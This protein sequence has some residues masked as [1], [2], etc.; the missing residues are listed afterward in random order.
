M[1][2]PPPPPPNSLTHTETGKQIVF[3]TNNSTKSRADYKKKL[4]NMG[5][6]C[7][8]LTPNPPSQDEVFGSSYSAAI[9]I[10]RILALPSPKNKIFVLG[11]AGIEAELR[12]ESLAYIGGS[13]PLLRRD[14]TPADYAGIASGEML[15]PDVGVV[16]CGLDFHI[17][18]LKLSLGYHYLQRGALFLATNTD[19]TLPAAG[20]FFPGAGATTAAALSAMVEG[21]KPVALGK[22][23]QAMM[24]AIEG[25]FRFERART[26]MVGDRLDTDIK[27]GI[28]GKLGGT[29]AVLTGVARREEWEGEGRE[30]VPAA[31]VDRLGDLMG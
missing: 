27:F 29:L 26:C 22:P 28:E 10:S 12:S 8:V 20:T 7:K 11:E 25:K 18:Y 5:I 21:R 31:F 13:D 23:S 3:V 14:I 19:S 9:Y 24:E 2:A 17:N 6:P 1:P 30:I 16:L 4:E 15:D